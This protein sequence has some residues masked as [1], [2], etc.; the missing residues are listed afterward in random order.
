MDTGGVKCWGANTNGALG[1]GTTTA[2]NVP[3]DVVGLPSDVV[4]LATSFRTSCALTSGGGVKCWGW[5]AFG[6]VGAGQSCGSDTC[7]APVDVTGLTSGVAAIS[8]HGIHAC[9]LTTTGGMKCWGMN[10]TAQ[11]GDGTYTTRYTPVD[12]SGLTGGVVALGAGVASS[13]AVVSG[14]GLKCWGLNNNGQLGDGTTTTRTTPIDVAGLGSGVIAVAT[15][16]DFIT[17]YS[18]HTCALTVEGAMKCWGSTYAG[19]L[20]DIFTCAHPCLAPADVF[21]DFDGD[22]CRDGAEQQTAQGSELSG[23]IRAPKNPHDYFNPT[24]DRENRVDDVLMVVNA[25][26]DDDTDAT[27]G[28][29]P[30]SPGYNPRT[31]RSNLAA[32]PNP[33]NTGAPDG[34]QRV[35]DIL[36]SVN[37]YFHDCS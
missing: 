7:L 13:C 27:P 2:S 6:Q 12:V 28:M 1:D 19:Q 24:G 36:H 4:A 33:W 14:G 37:S 8:A 26:Y 21:V 30:Y 10:N 23:G 31:D 29:P 11:L 20:G 3:V 34:L 17:N 32:S 35:Q 16:G 9:A 22:R 25:Y 5:D 18:P 15:S